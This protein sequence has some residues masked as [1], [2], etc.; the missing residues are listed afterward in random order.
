[1][2]LMSTYSATRRY[3]VGPDGMPVTLSE[4]FDIYSDLMLTSITDLVADTVD[5]VTGAVTK[6]GASLP[7]GT[8]CRFYRTNGSDTVDLIT[9]DGTVYRFLVTEQWPQ[10]INGLRLDEAFEGTMFAG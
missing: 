3:K 8:Q 2:D 4:Q 7:K 5:P 10:K 6:Q 9:E 1:M